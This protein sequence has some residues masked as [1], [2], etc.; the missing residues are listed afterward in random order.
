MTPIAIIICFTL[1]IAFTAAAVWGPLLIRRE[2]LMRR[3]V[4]SKRRVAAPRRE[5]YG[6]PPG[7]H[8][9]LGHYDLP[10]DRGWPGFDKVYEASSASSI[11][12]MI[13]RSA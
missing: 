8:R 11:S 7:M 3:N 10:D 9:A 4:A 1:L 2:G 6:P 5:K 13:E 12:H